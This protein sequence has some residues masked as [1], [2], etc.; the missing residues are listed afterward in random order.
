MAKAEVIA[1]KYDRS[2]VA[3]TRGGDI[4]RPCA[5]GLGYKGAFIP[6]VGI[7]AWDSR[8]QSID[9]EERGSARS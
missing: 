9:D 4:E 5:R 2:R 6:P 8:E 3:T 7:E 1:A